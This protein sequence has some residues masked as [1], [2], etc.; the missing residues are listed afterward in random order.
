MPPSPPKAMK[1]IFWR[2]TGRS[3]CF[4]SERKAVS[5]PLT[6]AAQFSNALWMKEVRQAV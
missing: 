3:P 1:F 6:V 4:F 5:T 2:S